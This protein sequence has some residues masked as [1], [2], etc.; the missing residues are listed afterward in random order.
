MA[1][2]AMLQAFVAHAEDAYE[3]VAEFLAGLVAA[4]GTASLD[5]ATEVAADLGTL[6]A[7]LHA[8][9]ATPPPDAPDLAPRE[10]TREELRAWRHDALRQLNLAVSA[11]AAVDRDLAREL[12]REAPAIAARVSRFEAVATTPTVMRIHADLHLG[13][14]LVADDGYRVIDFE[15][16][17]LRPYRGPAPPRFAAAGR[18]IAPPVARSRGPQRASPGG[19]ASQARSSAPVSTSTRGSSG[20]ASGSSPQRRRVCVRAAPR[21]PSTSTSS[22]R[23]RSRRSVTNSC[24]PP[25]CCHHGCGHRATGCAGCSR[26]GREARDDRRQNPRRRPG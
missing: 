12:E 17:P 4:P 21:S 23:S 9:L 14:I 8:A 13:Q 1:T 26:T 5:W 6:T 3:Q 16:E 18:G 20:R 24:T 22:T 10:A 15:G 2:V 11:V 19:A 7:G 25:R